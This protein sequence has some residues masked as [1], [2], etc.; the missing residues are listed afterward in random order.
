MTTA[1]TLVVLAGL[2]F[3]GVA[4]AGSPE[5]TDGS[6]AYAAEMKADAALRTSN[7]AGSNSGLLLAEGGD[8]SVKLGGFAQFRYINN[9]RD[10]PANGTSGHDSGYTNG[11][12]ATRTRLEVTG[13]IMS[14]ALTF[15]VDSDFSKSGGASLKDA[16]GQYAFDNGVKV[17]WGQFKL[18]VLREELVADVNQLAIDRSIVNTIFTQD[19]S[20]GI[21]AAYE[22]DQWRVMGAFSDGAGTL[23]TPYTSAAESDYAFSARGEFKWGDDWKR[24]ADFTSWRGQ[25][26]AGLVGAA[27]HY[28]HAGNTAN[29]SLTAMHSNLI[30]Y[31]ADFS[32]EGNGWN[33]FVAGVGRHFDPKDGESLDDFGLVVQAGVFVNDQIELF[34]RYDGVFA[35]SDY[36]NGLDDAFN[37]IGVGANYYVFAQSNA[38]KISADVQYFP[39][40]V[41]KN[42]LVT[43]VS[44]SNNNALQ[45]DSKGD[46]FAIRLQVQ[47]VF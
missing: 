13:N 26:N 47:L 1:K 19:R 34:A 14:K 8:T 29:S 6:R 17:K 30:E 25:S 43:G 9:F 24:F 46:Q 32:F 36:G 21:Q 28:Q 35:D 41:S 45:F 44:S 12:E 31:T 20:Q 10:N 38:F 39:D 42:A 11:F 5:T 18:P 7:L 23:N 2:T 27:I 37:T 15:K 40:K 3:G 16:W 4:V 22:Q 33:A